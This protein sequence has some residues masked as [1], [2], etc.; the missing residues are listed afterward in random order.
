MPQSISEQNRWRPFHA[1]GHG[2]AQRLGCVQRLV[3]GRHGVVHRKRSTRSLR[4]TSHVH[5]APSLHRQTFVRLENGSR[6]VAEN[7]APFLTF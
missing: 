1:A 7:C 5:F 6:C 2:G 3:A 4:G